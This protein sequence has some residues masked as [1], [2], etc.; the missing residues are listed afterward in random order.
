MRPNENVVMQHLKRKTKFTRKL[1]GE[2]YIRYL[3][4]PP[5]TSFYTWH[6]LKILDFSAHNSTLLH[7][8]PLRFHCVGECWDRT[9]YWCDFGIDCQTPL[10]HSRIDLIHQIIKMT[11]CP[12]ISFL[13]FLHVSRS[14]PE[15]G[16]DTGHGQHSRQ[17][18]LP[19]SVISF[20]NIQ[21]S[22]YDCLYFVR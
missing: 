1:V 17:G 7:L 16:G 11:T 13:Y 14:E 4:T 5:P 3:P 19:Q 10:N 21:I 6:M 12:L 20:A 9:Q 2:G 22:Y 18:P 15:R 8:P